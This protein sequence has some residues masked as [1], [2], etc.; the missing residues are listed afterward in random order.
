VAGVYFRVPPTYQVSATLLVLP[1]PLGGVYQAPAPPVPTTTPTPVPAPPK[2]TNPYLAFDTSTFIVARV[3]ADSLSGDA[4]RTV[5][6][7]RGGTSDYQATT[8]PA[9]PTV[10]LTV[11]GQDRAREVRTLHLLIADADAQL[12]ARQ[13]ATG[14]P[15]SYW[16]R[17]TPLVVADQPSSTGQRLKVAGGAA[18]LALVAALCLVFAVDGISTGRRLRVARAAAS[19]TAG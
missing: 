8:S 9:E 12:T 5:V 17:L 15:G 6:V 7:A 16:A 18:A 3:M 19:R 4:E 13:Q 10:S 1:P 11:T 14:L 2:L